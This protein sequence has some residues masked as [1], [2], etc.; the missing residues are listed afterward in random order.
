MNVLI[1]ETFDHE[2]GLT[3]SVVE[4][5][6]G[7]PISGAQVTLTDPND[8]DIYL[9]GKTSA[10]GTLNLEP[11]ISNLGE[12]R[13][14]V[15]KDRY[16]PII[17][18]SKAISS[19]DIEIDPDIQFIPDPPIFGETSK[20]VFKVKNNGEQ[21]IDE[22][23]IFWSWNE[24]VNDETINIT[25]GDTKLVEVV[26]FWDNGDLSTLDVWI[27]MAPPRMESTEQNNIA[28]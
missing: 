14:V 4:S 18:S 9:T 17:D 16:I 1:P 26:V 21:Y 22:L 20:V 12:L 3:I 6:N 28:S 10:E 5:L 13:I 11:R 7:W 25:G 19:W 15:T 2:E 27:N 8:P 24:T 23:A